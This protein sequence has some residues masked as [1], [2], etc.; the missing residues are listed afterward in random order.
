[1]GVDGLSAAIATQIGEAVYWERKSIVKEVED[2]LL[3]VVAAAER[4]GSLDDERASEVRS[5]AA[6]LLDV[7]GSVHARQHR[8][9][10]EGVPGFEAFKPSRHR[11][12]LA[13]LQRRSESSLKI[14]EDLV[15]KQP[16][17]RNQYG[18]HCARCGEWVGPYQGRLER[19]GSKWVV[20]HVGGRCLAGE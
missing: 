18:Q 14:L 11:V 17:S 2:L 5:V 16:G 15:G 20:R 3:R 6:A 8:D 1:M 4:A 10:Q 12:R 19:D 9:A 13:R 7:V